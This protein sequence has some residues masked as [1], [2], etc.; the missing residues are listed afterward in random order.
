MWIARI[1]SNP[2][3]EEVTKDKNVVERSILLTFRN[4]ASYI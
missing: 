2:K 3:D 1:I 4:L